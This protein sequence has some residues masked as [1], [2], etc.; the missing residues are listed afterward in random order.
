MTTATA[1]TRTRTVN[2]WPITTPN[3]KLIIEAE[4]IWTPT[5]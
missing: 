2:R 4:I 5:L 1:G 3:K